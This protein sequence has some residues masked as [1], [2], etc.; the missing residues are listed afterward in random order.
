MQ[1]AFVSAYNVRCLSLCTTVQCGLQSTGSIPP[2][3]GCKYILNSL[4]YDFPGRPPIGNAS[5]V[6]LPG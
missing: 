6:F 4:Q 5:S 2:L 1:W 3:H